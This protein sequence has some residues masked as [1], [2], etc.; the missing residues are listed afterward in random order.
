MRK[1]FINHFV[2]FIIAALFKACTPAANE[3]P[4]MNRL[5]MSPQP[6][7]HIPSAQL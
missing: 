6:M 2:I 3:L 4:Q 7:K 1:R 5:L